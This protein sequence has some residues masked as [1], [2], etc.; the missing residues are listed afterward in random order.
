MRPNILFI[1]THDT[2]RHL[3]CYGVPTVQS[4]NLDRLADEGVRFDRMF[5]TSALCTPARG[6]L[7][8]GRYPQTNGMM[9][10]CH[11]VWKWRLNEGEK[12]LSH[13]LKDAG[14]Y[15]ALYGHQH[16]TTDIPRDLCFDEQDLYRDPETHQHV[17]AEKVVEG[18]RS[19]LQRRA[20]EDQPFFLQLGFFETHRPFDFG[21][22]RPDYEKGVYVPPFLA[23][24]ETSRRDL[25]DFQGLIRKMDACVGAVLD[26]LDA[27]GLTENTIV[28]YTTDHGI[29][30]PKKIGKWA[31]A[32]VFDAGIGVAFLMRWPG[33]AIGGGQSCGKLLSHVDVAPTLLDLAEI[34]DP[35][36]LDGHSFAGVLADQPGRE[37]VYAMQ[38]CHG[39][40]PE[41]RCVRTDRYK[42]IREFAPGRDPRYPVDMND[43]DASSG[44]RPFV[45]LFDL[46][47]DPGETENLADEPRLAE[48]RG[49]LEARLARWMR[50]VNDPLLAGPMVP[51]YYVEA[52]AD[53]RAR[54][55]ADQAD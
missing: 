39:G 24:N 52:M 28:V 38:H 51:P 49:E 21:G 43:E 4:P 34:D 33:G 5:S 1:T 25:A 19:F 31:K 40:G 9:G 32:T 53:F 2:G 27:L 46:Q 42:L 7:M 44:D 23:D 47:A 55:P 8:T 29:A 45:R 26:E 16:E 22:A 17:P 15:T 37:A 35:G 41:Q 48:V 6:C 18:A 30:F 12:H 13:L 36:N 3:G 14:Y 11:G 50:S 10:L 20:G 54:C